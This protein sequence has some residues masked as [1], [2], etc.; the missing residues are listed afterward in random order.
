MDT[1]TGRKFVEQGKF[2]LKAGL[3]D[4]AW[5]K[6]TIH[7]NEVSGLEF[8][9]YHEGIYTIVVFVAPSCPLDSGPPTP[10]SGPQAQNPFYFLC[11]EKISSFSLHT[12]AYNL[13]V[14][15]KEDLTHLKSDLTKLLESKKQVIITGAA[16]GGSVA[17]LFTLWLL[18]TVDPKLKR[19]L[20]IT[21]GSPL[22]GDASLQQILENSLRN[23]CF[24]HVADAAQTPI[25]AGFKPFGTFLIYVGDQC[26]CID[27]P[28]T[29][30]ELLSGVNDD[31]VFS[32]MVER[33]ENKKRRFDPLKK[34]NH[35]KI[36]MMYLE[37][38]IKGCKRANMGFY[39]WYKTPISGE[40]KEK[41]K[42]RITELNQ[43][44]ASVVEEVEKMPQG[45]DSLL[46]TR[47]LYSANNY[48]R[49]VEPLVIAEYYRD[50]KREYRTRRS[51]HFVMLEKL[52]KEKQID[53][54]K[55]EKRDLTYLLTF[56]SCF[57]ADV[58][59]ALLLTN[60]QVVVSREVVLEKLIKFEED[61]WETI[62]KGEVSPEIFLEKSSFM[63]WWREY[64]KIKGSPSEYKKI[65][66][67]P[68]NFTEFM[69]SGEYKTYGQAS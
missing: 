25:Q 68:S 11:S 48:R 17:S 49:M 23:S 28:E 53:P 37:W 57:W 58:E 34:L 9:T 14:S 65:K 50:G 27:D 3:T 60:S 20:C 15:A 19:P 51:R 64:M 40:V 56:D 44:W 30:M 61:V 7:G 33:A 5:S 1:S 42:E 67:S 31:G 52:F 32:R 54:A 10:L 35:M 43:Y 22:L 63:K 59:E 69:I 21:F 38:Y 24:L 45:E 41:T 16:L 12:P 13:F 66:G 4:K 36:E 46:K 26:I 55:L 29:V 62:K 47:S 2:V 18:D 8:K 6:I 39:D